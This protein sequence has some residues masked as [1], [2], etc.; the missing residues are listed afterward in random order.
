MCAVCAGSARRSSSC[1]T[2]L[3]STQVSLLLQAVRRARRAREHSGLVSAATCFSSREPGTRAV[4]R[5]RRA[6][7]PPL[8]LLHRA[9]RLLIP[10][11]CARL[12]RSQQSARLSRR[13]RLHQLPGSPAHVII[14]H[15][16]SAYV[17]LAAG[18]CT[19][20]LAHLQP[21]NIR[22]PPRHRQHLPAPLGHHR[23]AGTTTS[24]SLV[25]QRICPLIHL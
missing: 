19:S 12:S 1:R 22:Q 4:R 9:I 15:H 11:Q 8:T 13:L 7:A 3:A 23:T 17:F 16:T 18:V 25:A 21:V 14:R 6:R 2:C 20:C 24:S 10:Q 5:T